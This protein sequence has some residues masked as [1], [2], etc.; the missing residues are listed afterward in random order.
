MATIVITTFRDILSYLDQRGVVVF[1]TDENQLNTA[2][3]E[4]LNDQINLDSSLQIE[5]YR[6]EE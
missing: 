5:E 6:E 1:I 2:I 3:S 4:M